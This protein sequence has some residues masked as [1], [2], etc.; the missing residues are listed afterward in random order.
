[1]I[2][3]IILILQMR[4]VRHRNVKTLIQG[5]TAKDWQSRIP[6]RH[7]HESPLS[8]FLI[9]TIMFVLGVRRLHLS[10][11]QDLAPLG[12]PA[13]QRLM[14]QWIMVWGRGKLVHKSEQLGGRM[15]GEDPRFHPVLS[16][17]L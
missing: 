16:V 1:M 5:H 14:C 4:R 13:S 3:I 17:L 11:T 2:E 15:A 6:T 12:F 7:H 8:Y 9:Y 10:G